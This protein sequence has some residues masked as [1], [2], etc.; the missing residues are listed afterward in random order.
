MKY[1]FLFSLQIESVD[2]KSMGSKVLSRKL[3]YYEYQLDAQVLAALFRGQLPKRPG[4]AKNDTDED[5]DWDEIDE[6]DWDDL[7]DST[8]G[9]IT[10]CLRPQPEERP[11]ASHIQEL[12]VDIKAWDS[13]PAAKGV[14]GA[15][16][17]KQKSNIEVNLNR[18]GMLL[19]QLQVCYLFFT[20][21]L[22]A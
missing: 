4:P 10:K 18:A 3:P 20:M 14:P 11:S 6:K 1:V 7:D 12:I 5:D 2:M 16:I 19:D 15:E 9:W 8:W 13:R 21:K 22:Q 17:L